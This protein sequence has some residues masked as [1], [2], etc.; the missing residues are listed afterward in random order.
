MTEFFERYYPTLCIRRA[1]M[2][3]ME[4][5]PPTEKQKMLPIVLL[6]PWLN[7]IKFDN[8]FERIEISIG[9]LPIIVDLDRFYQSE[10]H[11]ESRIYF[12]SLLK[13]DGATD[14]WIELITQHDNYIP[15]VQTVDRS[16]E[17]ISQQINVFKE[18]GRGT[19]FRF[20]I[21]AGV[22]PSILDKYRDEIDFGNTLFVIDGGWVDYNQVTEAKIEG[23]VNFI[24]GLSDDAR[25]VVCCSNFP[26]DFSDLDNMAQVEIS[27]RRFYSSIRERYGNY[28]IFYGDWASTKPR[29]YDGF[30]S[31]PLARIDF[32]LKDR[33][34]IAR[35]KDE[36]WDF[37][38]A[39]LRITRLPEWASRPPVWGA[40]L[41]DKAA[42]NEPGAITTGPQAIAARVNIHLFMQNN[43]SAEDVTLI[44]TDAPWED[45]I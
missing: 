30:G 7:S 42:K 23:F 19:V 12:R 27:S 16:D 15:T 18:L 43:F 24:T 40:T 31:K 36:Q 34:I 3:A 41:I 38:D 39:A 33:W 5:L 17:C 21:G 6:A 44:P 37:V 45:P 8:T 28:Q 29:R 10:S 4:K 9:N 35:S 2:L 14:R 11:N 22:T 32:P 20:E 26:N 1:E 13:G 25:I